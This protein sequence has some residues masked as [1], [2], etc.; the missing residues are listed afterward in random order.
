MDAPPEGPAGSGSDDPGEDLTA[1]LA[2]VEQA[3]EKRTAA[4]RMLRLQLDVQSIADPVTGLLNRNGI[5]DSIEL[6]LERRSR[7]R[8]PFAVMTVSFPGLAD[9][10]SGHPLHEREEALR[11]LGAIM[12]AAL[13]R[14]DRSGWLGGL[15][16][17]AVMPG[18]T[19]SDAEAVIDRLRSVL[20]A[21]PVEAGGGAHQP[22][23]RVAA[24]LAEPGRDADAATIL[25]AAVEGQ[26][27]AAA[28]RPSIAF[29]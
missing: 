24:V 23:P 5:V 21:A 11:H 22:L 14:L 1:R 3:L 7:Y 29:L 6:A 12:T 4:L 15:T 17:A 27:R 10:L 28:S 8:E 19:G 2:A 25:R 13:R 20:S 26:S 16:F 18:L 9:A